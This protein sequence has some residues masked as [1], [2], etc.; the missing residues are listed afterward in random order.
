MKSGLEQ[1]GPGI[2][3]VKLEPCPSLNAD[4]PVMCQLQC[5]G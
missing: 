3:V 4:V 5:R 1:A 2:P